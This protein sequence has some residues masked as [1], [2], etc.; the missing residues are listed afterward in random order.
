M[1]PQPVI[2]ISSV[3]KINPRA[4]RFS[5]MKVFFLK[6]LRFSRNLKKLQAFVFHRATIY[7]PRTDFSF[8]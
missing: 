1:I 3:T 6:V 5:D 4:G 2:S 8:V 7:N